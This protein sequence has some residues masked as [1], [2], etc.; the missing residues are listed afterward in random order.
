MLE[1]WKSRDGY[2]WRGSACFTPGTRVPEAPALYTG[3]RPAARVKRQIWIVRLRSH[4]R[5]ASFRS[6]TAFYCLQNRENSK[7]CHRANPVHSRIAARPQA[8]KISTRIPCIIRTRKLP[9]RQ[10]TASQFEN[11]AGALA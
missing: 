1:S 10:K 8:E 7:Y 9:R 6:D 11:T 5:S 4:V 3:R 2:E